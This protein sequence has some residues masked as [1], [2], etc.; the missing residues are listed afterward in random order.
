MT[1]DVCSKEKGDFC[2]GTWEMPNDSRKWAQEEKVRWKGIVQAIGRP[3][4]IQSSGKKSD[5]RRVQQGKRDFCQDTCEMPILSWKY[6]HELE[7]R[8]GGVQRH[9]QAIG[10]RWPM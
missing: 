2:R 10:R 8:E 9:V 7:A 6:S 3:E 1:A 5:C 4:P